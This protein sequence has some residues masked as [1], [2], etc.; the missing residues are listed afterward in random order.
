MTIVKLSVKWEKLC[1]PKK[2]G[3]LGIKNYVISVCW[4]SG[5]DKLSTMISD[6]LSVIRYLY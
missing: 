5:N 6:L 4:E 1:L 3:D 2:S